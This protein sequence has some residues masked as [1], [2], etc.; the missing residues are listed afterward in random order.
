[1][2]ATPLRVPT[3]TQDSRS[4]ACRIPTPRFPL[5]LDIRCPLHRPVNLRRIHQARHS[6][7]PLI[8]ASTL[9]LKHQEFQ[10][11]VLF[12]LPSDQN[13]HTLSTVLL[14]SNGQIHSRL[15]GSRGENRTK[16]QL[17]P[18]HRK[19]GVEQTLPVYLRPKL[20]VLKKTT[21]R[22]RHKRS[23]VQES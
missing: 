21:S 6:L 11:H 23:K 17:E 16:A 10:L 14:R 15:T 5:R 20:E 18:R 2:N 4:L 9:T 12:S 8:S 1:M 13:S 3:T 19:R 22:H 7:R